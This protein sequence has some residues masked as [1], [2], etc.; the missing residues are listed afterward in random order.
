LPFQEEARYIQIFKWDSDKVLDLNTI[1]EKE[2]T[3]D[4]L[5][6]LAKRYGPDKVKKLWDDSTHDTS[7]K[8]R[9]IW[10]VMW[11]LT[12]SGQ[13]WGH[14]LRKLG[15]DVVMD[16]GEGIIHQSEPTQGI[17]L[18]PRIITH[19]NQIQ[20]TYAQ[21]KNIARRKKQEEKIESAISHGQEIP[22]KLLGLVATNHSWAYQ[23]AVKVLKGRFPTGESAIAKV[24]R[25]ACQYAQLILKGRFPEG[26]PAIAKDPQSAYQYAHDVLK[27]P[28]PE[29]ESAI[30]KDPRSAY[31]YA[32]DV[33]KGRFPAGEPAIAND[34]WHASLYAK[35]VLKDSDPQTWAQRYLAGQTK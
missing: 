23:Y 16:N 18:N 5:P 10:Y 24:P 15:Y 33:L 32:Y 8:S 27:G 9:R 1:T 26:E 3:Q 31:Q 20:Q 13:K 12:K 7:V 29:G 6:R 28:F 25:L 17:V 34:D 2:I 19:M 30:A 22:D 21:D 11:K 35:N 14:L 4:I